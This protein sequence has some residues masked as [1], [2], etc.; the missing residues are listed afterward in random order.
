MKA[1]VLLRSFGLIPN[2]EV[3]P[4]DTAG[5]TLGSSLSRE[6]NASRRRGIASMK[7]TGG[8]HGFHCQT[9]YL[10]AL[11]RKERNLA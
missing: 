6:A 4:R 9:S 2:A 10:R 8:P 5:H 11:G 7:K 3:V 1:Q